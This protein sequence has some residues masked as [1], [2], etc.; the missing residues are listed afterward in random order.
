MPMPFSNISELPDNIKELPEKKQKQFLEVFNSAL[1]KCEDDDGDDCESSAFAQANGAVKDSKK[2]QD[3][4]PNYRASGE[5]KMSCATCTWAANQWCT[6][7][8]FLFEPAN[9]CD[10]WQPH[11]RIFGSLVEVEFEKAGRRH[12][13]KDNRM[14]QD[15]HDKAVHLGAECPEPKGKTPPTD[16]YLKAISETEEELRVGNYIV[17]FG[18]RDLEGV[19]SPNKN[20][21]GSNGE[22]FTAQ[23][24]LESSYTKA[25]QVAI[26]WEHGR[27]AKSDG[28][29]REDVLGYVDWATKTVDDFGVFVER[30]LNRR[31]KYV[32]WIEEL[33]KR[34][35]VGSSSE[36]IQN[37]IQKSADGE[38]TNWPLFRDSLTVTPMEPRML[39]EFGT[40][41]LEAL[42]ALNIINS[43]DYRRLK[44]KEIELK[45]EVLNES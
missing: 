7:Y 28:L 26:D 33:I 13:S 35:L 12:S 45:L 20:A 8:D 37:D 21:D 5:E 24:N 23:T 18:G 1:K 44:Q 38:I 42:K 6:L 9:V 34:G 3:D 2:T 36:P 43:L 40:N 17:L 19:A 29:G 14:L 41:T 22:Y 4:A 32:Q 27:R 15:I 39:K 11:P 25:G 10:S 16:N 30:V 31:N